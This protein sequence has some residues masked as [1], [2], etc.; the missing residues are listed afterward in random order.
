M[1]AFLAV[2]L[3]V[4]VTPGAA[5]CG[6][7]AAARKAE[8]ATPPPAGFHEALRPAKD[9]LLAG[10]TDVVKGAA[11]GYFP[12]YTVPFLPL[13]GIALK[14]CRREVP[15]AGGR[16]IVFAGS[17]PVAVRIDGSRAEVWGWNRKKRCLARAELKWPT[18]SA[19]RAGRLVGRAA[20]IEFQ[21]PSQK[22]VSTVP[23]RFEAELDPGKPGKERLEVTADGFLIQ[24]GREVLARYVSRAASLGARLREATV[25]VRKG[26]AG[27]YRITWSVR[28]KTVDRAA[29]S[30]RGTEKVEL[31][32]RP[33]TRR[34][35]WITANAQSEARHRAEGCLQEFVVCHSASLATAWG[36][37]WLVT[38][39]VSEAFREE[40]TSVNPAECGAH[41][42]SE[43]AKPSQLTTHYAV[44][45]TPSG[46][47]IPLDGRPKRMPTA[48]TPAT[49]QA[50]LGGPDACTDGF[51]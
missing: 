18:V 50:K 12:G 25:E 49:G 28:M 21:E 33:A 46:G 4:S 1:Q 47:R 10:S 23:S 39:T 38:S 45:V 24:S 27:R 48:Q 15:A 16:Y 31:E 8:L 7:K 42:P 19:R 20:Y 35:T 29:F 5:A 37:G 32:W 3:V 17:V 30:G 13:D 40:N 41:G 2:L 34:L 9:G 14:P 22:P 44:W 36:D 11:W 43:P 51:E 6:P 26:R